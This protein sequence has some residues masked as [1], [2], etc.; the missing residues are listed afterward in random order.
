MN[1]LY[2]MCLTTLHNKSD[3]SPFK[4]NFNLQIQLHTTYIKLFLL[5]PIFRF[6]TEIID[7]VWFKKSFLYQVLSVDS[8]AE[9]KTWDLDTLYQEEENYTKKFCN[10]PG[11]IRSQES[12]FPGLLGHKVIINLYMGTFTY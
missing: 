9:V 1:L 12:Y 7:N 6:E 4:E 5:P 10:Q 2:N 11:G 3:N 8:D